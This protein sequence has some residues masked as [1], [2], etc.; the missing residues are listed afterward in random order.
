MV[1]T[2]RVLK[3]RSS[4]CG[5]NRAKKSTFQ[6][7]Q[8]RKEQEEAEAKAKKEAKKADKWQDGLRVGKIKGALGC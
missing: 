4:T 1:W 6:E 2:R 8:R 5:C 3:E 7:E